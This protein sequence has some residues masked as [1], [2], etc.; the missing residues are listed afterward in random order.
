MK[1]SNSDED[2]FEELAQGLPTPRDT[3]SA[4]QQYF[5]FMERSVMQLY[6]DPVPWLFNSVTVAIA[7]FMVWVINLSSSTAKLDG[8][9]L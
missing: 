6:Y 8:V 3:M 4:T 5:L 1:D 2:E 9:S 7:A